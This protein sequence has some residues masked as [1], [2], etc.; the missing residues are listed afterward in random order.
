MSDARGIDYFNRGHF[1]SSIQ[2]RA[3]LALRRRMFD[4]WWKLAKPTARTVLDIG[5]TPDQELEDSN[6]MPVWLEEQ[7]IFC[8]LYSPEDIQNLQTRFP[9]AQ[10]LKEIRRAQG[11]I[12]APSYDWV[13][14]SAVIEH[15]GNFAAQKQFILDCLANGRGIF[16]TTPNRWHWLEFHTKLPLIHW[17]PKSWHRRLLRVLGLTTWSH[18]NHL[19]LVSASDLGLMMRQIEGQIGGLNWQVRRYWF[20]GLPSNLALIAERRRA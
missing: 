17:L 20:L 16:L 2:Q 4:D 15:V 12:T 1:L 10:I 18:E 3:S 7:G 11:G 14:S 19:N 9:R 8:D 5:A 13:M 6:C